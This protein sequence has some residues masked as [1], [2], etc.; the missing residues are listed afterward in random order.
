LLPGILILLDNRAHQDRRFAAVTPAD[1]EKHRSDDANEYYRQANG[2]PE[3]AFATQIHF[4]IILARGCTANANG[5][6]GL[7]ACTL[8]AH[9]L[10]IIKSH[11]RKSGIEEIFAP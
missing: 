5:F 10:C 2:M 7:M 6:F 1:T 4:T 9:R 3:F 11:T 8:R